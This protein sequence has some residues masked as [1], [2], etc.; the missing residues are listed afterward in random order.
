MKGNMFLILGLALVVTA[1]L[2]MADDRCPPVDD[3][4]QP[5]VLLP[6]PSDCSKFLICSH[7][8]AIVSKCPPGLHWNDAH[9]QCDYPSQ[10]QCL[11]ES[12]TQ[13]APEPSANCPEVYDPDHM[14]YVPHEQ[15]CSRYYICDPFG[16]E[17]EQQCPSG[18]HWN[19]LVN[20]CDFPE[21]AQCEERTL[22]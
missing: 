3:P 4:L 21:L 19:P 18:L 9:K 12:E 6:Y 11:P 15:D 10:A 20:Y 5:P 22:E 2:S 8:H 16:V 7:G 17:L 1:D 14:V 13:N